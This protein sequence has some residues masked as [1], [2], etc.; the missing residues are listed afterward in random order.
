MSPE[1]LPMAYLA[2]IKIPNVTKDVAKL[3]VRE[4]RFEIVF[5]ERPTR[6]SLGLPDDAKARKDVKSWKARVRND[7]MKQEELTLTTWLM[8]PR[9]LIHPDCVR[10]LPAATKEGDVLGPIEVCIRCRLSNTTVEKEIAA[11]NKLRKDDPRRI[12]LQPKRDLLCGSTFSID[13]FVDLFEGLSDED[14][15]ELIEGLT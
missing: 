11:I 14:M 10:V 13:R 1:G 8:R 2:Y 3:L 6:E 12:D 9:D 4:E 15:E 7:P 5:H